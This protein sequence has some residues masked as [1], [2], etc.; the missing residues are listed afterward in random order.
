MGLGPQLNRL[1]GESGQVHLTWR[2]TEPAITKWLGIIPV[3]GLFIA[4]NI[5][6][7]SQT[8][9]STGVSVQKLGHTM[10]GPRNRRMR[11]ELTIRVH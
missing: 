10:C 2:H 1:V 4:L 7:G 6:S 11:C 8:R 5:A 9:P 3:V